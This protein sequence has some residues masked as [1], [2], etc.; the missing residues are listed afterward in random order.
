MSVRP[1]DICASVVPEVNA[2]KWVYLLQ[3]ALANPEVR[4]GKWI[5]YQAALLI[6]RRVRK[7]QCIVRFGDFWYA[8]GLTVYLLETRTT[9]PNT[10]AN[11]NHIITVTTTALFKALL[12]ALAFYKSDLM[13]AFLD[14]A[15]SQVCSQRAFKR[16]ERLVFAVPDSVPAMISTGAVPHITCSSY[17]IAVVFGGIAG[18]C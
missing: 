9:A 7:H 11:I 2:W 1:A 14:I 13:R 6:K 10:T 5:L 16:V 3:L 17:I 4:L 15:V 18:I 12:P 8:G